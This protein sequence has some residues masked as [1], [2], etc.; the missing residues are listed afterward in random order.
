M[1]QNI[2]YSLDALEIT[3]GMKV[4]GK[5]S[6]LWTNHVF[7]IY[8]SVMKQAS[9]S[10]ETQKEREPALMFISVWWSDTLKNG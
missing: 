1:K 3:E 4:D 5:L 8:V 10:R 9:L 7:L 2:L 6:N